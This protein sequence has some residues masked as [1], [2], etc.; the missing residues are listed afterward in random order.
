MGPVFLSI[1]GHPPTSIHMAGKNALDKQQ[2]DNTL[3]MEIN[4]TKYTIHEFFG[5]KETINEII[6][7]RVE[8]DLNPPGSN[9]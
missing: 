1:I 8:S 2:P 4:G 3:T 6:A 7:K 9:N 5:G